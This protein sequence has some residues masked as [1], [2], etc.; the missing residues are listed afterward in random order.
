MKSRLLLVLLGFACVVLLPAA[1]PTTA[2]HPP[3]LVSV[4]G[5]WAGGWQMKKVAPL[6]EAKGWLVYRPSLPG[7][8]EHFHTARADIGLATHIDDIVNFILFEN[9]HDVI[10][11]G[12]SYGGMVITGVADR[13]PE[14]IR[15]LVYLDAFV[16]ENGESV[17]TIRRTGAPEIEKMAKDGFVI[18]G[19]V[20][21]DKPFPKDVP[22][23]LKTFTDPIVLKNPAAA[24]IPATYILT[25]DKG[26]QPEDDDFFAA[27][28][29]ARARGWPVIIMEG[30]HVVNWRQPEATAEL[31]NGLR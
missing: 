20:K 2:A 31:L 8:G 3:V 29:R 26:K 1:E 7:L 13:I 9:L 15:R 23:P 21:P 19:W 17:M 5:A 18:P 22:H 12:H 28:E 6:L 25:V 14:R 30:D 4:H 27:A 24:K 11:L 16:P 10:L